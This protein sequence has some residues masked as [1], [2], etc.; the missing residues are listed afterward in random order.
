VLGALLCAPAQLLHAPGELVA[1]RLELFQP[2][3]ARPR[4]GTRRE[5]GADVREALRDDR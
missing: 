5:H 3:Q 1:K 4:G 2:H